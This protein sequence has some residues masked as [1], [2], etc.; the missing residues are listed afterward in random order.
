L[1]VGLR[2]ALE[3]VKLSLAALE[4]L[5]D[6][7]DYRSELLTR[8]N[9]KLRFESAIDLQVFVGRFQQAAELA[10]VLDDPNTSPVRPSTRRSATCLRRD[11]DRHPV[12]LAARDIGSE[13]PAR[14]HGRQH[15]RSEAA[16][17]HPTSV[18]ETLRHLAKVLPPA[19][20]TSSRPRRRRRS[21]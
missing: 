15:R 3:R 10:T 17:H 20:S 16:A 21:S 8:E 11:D 6:D 12:Q 4:G 13:P 19:Y 7:A 9:G 18:V 5:D 1:R 2:R 14:A